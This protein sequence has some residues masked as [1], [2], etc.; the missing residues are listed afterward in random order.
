MTADRLLNP[1]KMWLNSKPMAAPATK[2]RIFTIGHSNRV[3][4]EF[5]AMLDVQKLKLVVDV[6]TIPKSHHNPQYNG[7]QLA[8]SL[9]RH[10]IQY[11]HILGLGGLRRTRKDSP[12]QGWRNSSF[13]GYADY[14]QTE[15]FD[16]NLR[17]LI[18]LSKRKRLVIMCAEA[19][20]WRCHR[21]LI[22]DALLARGLAVSDLLDMGSPKPHKMTS[23]AKMTGIRVSYPKPSLSATP[24]QQNQ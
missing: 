9:E 15:E 11:I 24:F 18:A 16:K 21:S 1:L 7:L 13:R 19:L 3:I 17:K 4:E 20:P 2:P 12:N 6:R 14:M 5:V 23:F 10:G 8:K 22:A